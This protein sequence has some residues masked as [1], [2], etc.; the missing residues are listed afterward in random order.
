MNFKKLI[1]IGLFVCVLGAAEGLFGAQTPSMRD[2][3]EKNEENFFGALDDLGFISSPDQEEVDSE[4]NLLFTLAPLLPEKEKGF[5]EF[6]VVEQQYEVV[7]NDTVDGL[8]ILMK[9]NRLY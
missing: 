8:K 7:H 9:T 5:L 1:I 3:A 2:V 4:K 6:P